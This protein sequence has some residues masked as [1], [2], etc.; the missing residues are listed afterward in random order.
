[1]LVELPHSQ[2][3]L[4]EER[5]S[6]LEDRSLADLL[7]RQNPELFRRAIELQEREAIGRRFSNAALVLLG[8]A[9]LVAGYVL[10]PNAFKQ[11]AAH[12]VAHPIPAVAQRP[13]PAVV[14]HPAVATHHHA[15]V[16]RAAPAVLAASVHHADAVVVK[17]QARIAA[18]EAAARAAQR[19]PQVHPAAAPATTVATAAE[20]TTASQAATPSQAAPNAPLD[21]RLLIDAPPPPDGTK[22]APPTALSGHWTPQA[23]V[24]GQADPCTPQGGRA[25]IIMQSLGRGL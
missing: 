10:A 17:L 14:R 3:E 25:G 9:S 6:A 22:A 15:P 8:V 12:P 11:P 16:H 20:S 5:L 13:T 21:P 18:H 4:V 1:M 24:G 23:N 19:H 7:I 2:P